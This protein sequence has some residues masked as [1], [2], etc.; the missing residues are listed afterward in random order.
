MP[1]YQ[2]GCVFCHSGDEGKVA[3]YIER[4]C[5]ETE[6]LVAQRIKL[7]RI[8]GTIIE[9]IETMFPGYVF[10]RMNDKSIKEADYL[11][12]TLNCKIL[13]YSGLNKEWRLQGA[14]KELALKLYETK[15]LIRPIKA[16]MINNR[17]EIVDKLF[18]GKKYE[19]VRANHRARTLQIRIWILSREIIM[20]V[21]Y[22]LV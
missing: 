5:A 21:N 3:E 17:V 14:D 22:R 7:K 16:R 20:W 9:E 1:E 6:A 10:F 19:V 15:G 2:Y 8:A 11:E 12:R 18:C 13:R 4:N